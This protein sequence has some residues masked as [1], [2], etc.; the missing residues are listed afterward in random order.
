[1]GSGEEEGDAVSDEEAV[2]EADAEGDVEADTDGE[3]VGLGDGGR[4]TTARTLFPPSSTT[5]SAEAF[6]A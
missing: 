6:S 3:G 5:T 1:M 4:H 2:A